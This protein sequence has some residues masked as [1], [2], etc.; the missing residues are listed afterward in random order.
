M[1][2]EKRI[3]DIVSRLDRMESKLDALMEFRWKI[4]GGQ[5]VIS[6][7]VAFVISLIGIWV[8]TL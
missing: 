4:D 6:A 1:S 7:V 3:D 2:E 8:R 5:M